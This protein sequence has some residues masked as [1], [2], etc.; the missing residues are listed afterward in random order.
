[1]RADGASVA[2]QAGWMHVIRAGSCGAGSR[3]PSR[4]ISSATSPRW[5]ANAREFS[6][7]SKARASHLL[8]AQDYAGLR[9]LEKYAVRCGG[10]FNHRFGLETRC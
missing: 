8:H 4:S 7:A 2:T 3:T 1:M 5:T 10:G 9:A 6:A